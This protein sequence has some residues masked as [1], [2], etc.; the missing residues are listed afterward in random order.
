[1]HIVLSLADEI[2]IFTRCLVVLLAKKVFPAFL[3][4]FTLFD[5]GEVFPWVLAESKFLQ[6]EEHNLG[7]RFGGYIV[8]IHAFM[9]L[10]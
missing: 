6:D 3:C 10:S 4:D 2:F 9:I 8:M 5:D 1:M 7:F